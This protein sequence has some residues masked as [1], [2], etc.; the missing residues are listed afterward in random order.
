MNNLIL[1]FVLSAI[2]L[3]TAHARCKMIKTAGLSYQEKEDIVNMHNYL[4]KVVALGLVAGQPPASNML[5]MVW[6]EEL[7]YKAQNWAD[8]CPTGHDSDKAR[9]VSRFP[10]G[11]NIAT[12]W[13]SPRPD[14]YGEHPDFISQ[15]Y[16]WFNEVHSYSFSSGFSFKTGHY[17]QMVW[18]NS[19]LVGC[20]YSY[21]HDGNKYVKKYIC[22][23]GPGGNIA[24]SKPY[25]PG[26]ASCNLQGSVP[27]T[28]FAGLCRKY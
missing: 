19:F 5:E 7:A 4:R 13:S 18:D 15:I 26:S 1:L 10:V 25:K 12:T 6:D 14:A 27:S 3:T 9:R 24:G 8:Q 11:Q 28:R 2:C 17:S 22:D 21:Y 20:G 16:N 23:Y